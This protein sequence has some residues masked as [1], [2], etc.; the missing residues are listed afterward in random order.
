MASSWLSGNRFPSDSVRVADPFDLQFN[1]N[2]R[3]DYLEVLELA[4]G[5]LPLLFE[6]HLSFPHT[7]QQ[8]IL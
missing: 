7:C 3:W 1:E 6:L 8:D 5:R 2:E 4:S